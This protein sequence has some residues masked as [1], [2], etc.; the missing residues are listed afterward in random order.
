MQE[1]I[2]QVAGGAILYDPELLETARND[3][4]DPAWWSARGALA[5]E[6]GGR[7]R[8]LFLQAPGRMGD[9]QWVLRRFRRGGVVRHLVDTRYLWLGEERTRGFCEWR[10]LARL[11]DAGLPVPRPVAARYQRVGPLFYSAELITHRLPDNRTLRELY[12]DD[13]VPPG[14]WQRVGA[15]VRR[16][17]EAGVFHADLNAGNLLVTPEEVVYIVDFDQARARG[18]GRWRG[19]NLARLKR[20]LQ[21]TA[22]EAGRA[23]LDPAHWQSLLAGYHRPGV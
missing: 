12:A 15:V 8:V 17:H 7:G 9:G 19:R 3:W 20:S 6:A 18:P 5:G 4:F 22:V 10:I 16:V 13:E 2:Q 21:K 11:H 14:V 23:A 1:A